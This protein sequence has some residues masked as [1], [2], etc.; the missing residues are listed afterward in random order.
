MPTLLWREMLS[1]PCSDSCYR[2][3]CGLGDCFL[4]KKE[5]F[6]FFFNYCPLHF[7]GNQLVEGIMWTCRDAGCLHHL[8]LSRNPYGKLPE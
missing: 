5:E 2:V 6:Y 1:R 4:A 7:N 8:S 3:F